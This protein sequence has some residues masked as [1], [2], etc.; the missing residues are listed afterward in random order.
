[1][2]EE[3]KFEKLFSTPL[4]R[5]QVADHDTLSSDLLSEAAKLRAA[6]EGLSKSNRR[7]WHSS[8]NIF[9]HEADCV[10]FLRVA[11]EASIME[12]TRRITS[13]IDPVDLQ[14]KLF[15]WMNANPEG[16]YNSPHTHPGAHWSGVYYVSQP[17]IDEGNSGMIEFVAPR[18][19]LSHWRILK[20]SAFS[21]K[22]RIRPKAGELIL[23]PSYLLH[24]VYPNEAAEERV[25]LA[26]NATFRKP[27]K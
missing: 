21:L 14:M 4:L 19:D 3:T 1:M 5:Y 23:F 26:F 2:I 15:G 16:G 8:G 12:A 20:A 10:Q 25:T 27:K 17:D 11:V 22:K 18:T 9:D 6:D 24:W 7:G 13:K